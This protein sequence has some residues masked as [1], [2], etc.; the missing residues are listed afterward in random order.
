MKVIRPEYIS[1]KDWAGA[2]VADYFNEP[3]PILENEEKWEEWGTIVAT[4]GVFATNNI[5]A[6]SKI[7]E[8]RKSS[9]FKDWQ[10]WAKAVYSLMS[11]SVEKEK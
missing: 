4:T 10:E 7:N 6:P 11:A 5:P 3:L 1:L 2:L 9:G 8:G